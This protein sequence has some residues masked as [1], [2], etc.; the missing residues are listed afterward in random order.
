MKKTI[1][2]LLLVS[3]GM[4]C[5][6]PDPVLARVGTMDVKTSAFLN[7]VKG[8]PFSSPSYL[9][10]PA[11]RRELLELL[12]RRKIILME[13]QKKTSPETTRLMKDLKAEFKERQKKLEDDFEREQ[14]RL[15]VGQ[16]T[17]ELKKDELKITDEEIRSFWETESEIHAR[18]ILVSQR[19]LAED[20][21]RRIAQGEKFEALAQKYS[22]D[23]PSA[24]QG[25]DA[26]FLL[27]GLSVPAFQKAL[28]ALK[29]GEVSGVVTSPY[30]YHLIQQIEARRLNQSPLND[31]SKTK[32]RQ[33]LESQKL[34]AW[35]DRAREKHPVTVNDDV[36]TKLVFPKPDE[37]K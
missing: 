6:K 16:F 4:G 22:E 9:N 12:V 7:E 21:I 32:I 26:G 8:V 37:P 19:L 1:A 25:G 2:L 30:G 35:F 31:T 23:I 18:H 10:T 5:R 27:K 29:T 15:V 34:Q 13:A 17:N 36:L 33:A 3:T 24:K 20:L 14:D 11:G 28:F